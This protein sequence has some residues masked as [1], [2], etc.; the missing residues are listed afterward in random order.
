MKKNQFINRTMLQLT[1]VAS[2]FLFVSCESAQSQKGSKIV[3]EKS[4]DEKFDNNKHEKDAQFLVNAAE[5]NLKEIQ[6]G[7]MAQQNGRTIHIKKLGKMMEDAHTESQQDLIVL[8]K[9]KSISIPNT[10]TDDSL[11]AYTKL[12]EKSG[13]DFDNAYA[14]NMVSQHENAIE[15]FEKAS[16]DCNDHDIKNWAKAT[17]PQL[18]KHLDQSME[19]QKKYAKM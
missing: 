13:N 19:Y 7:Q 9:S 5:I 6:L 15:V 12:N 1:L 8:A 4:N 3:A 18:Q 14:N 16:K 17:L 10:P 2:I 11:D